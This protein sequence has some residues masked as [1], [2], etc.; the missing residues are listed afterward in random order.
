MAKILY[1]DIETAPAQVYTW[2]LFKPHIGID[3]IISPSRILG[4][5]YM[6]HGQKKARWVSEYHNSRKE[7]L[8]TI[9]D[10]FDE[11]DIVIGYN[12]KGFDTPWVKGE[13]LVEGYLP[14]APFLEVDLYQVVKRNTRLLSKK[15][16]YVSELLLGEN[17]V[18]HSGFAMWKGCIE[19]DPDSWEL[20]KKYALVDTEL[21]PPLYEKLRPWI[22][23]HPNIAL[24]D[25][26]EDLSCPRCGS[27]DHQRRGYLH[28]GAGRFQRLRCNDCGSWFRMFNRVATTQGRSV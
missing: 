25:S 15:L 7:M 17:K 28:T 22:T 5:S 1:Y 16:D 14:P 19:G 8:D 13:L 21:L 11:A 12:S 20:M 24:I 6:W 10:L 26:R 3:Q 23:N 4:F 18:K 9:H 2:S 27:E